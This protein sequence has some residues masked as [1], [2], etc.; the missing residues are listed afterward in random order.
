MNGYTSSPAG[1]RLRLRLICRVSR[2]ATPSTSRISAAVVMDVAGKP[3]AAVA[4]VKIMV[5]CS[6]CASSPLCRWITA[7]QGPP[8]SFAGSGTG[9]WNDWPGAMT[10][11]AAANGPARSPS[12]R[13]VLSVNDVGVVA[14][15]H[16][17]GSH[18][19]DPVQ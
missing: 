19:A 18:R 10:V 1:V 8:G 5:A 12:D 9:T 17:L 6:L 14:E 15:V 7:C 2:T 16:P 11:G 4:V 13:G 3:R